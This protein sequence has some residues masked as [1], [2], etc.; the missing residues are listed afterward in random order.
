M[1]PPHERNKPFNNRTK[2]TACTTIFFFFL[3]LVFWLQWFLANK[4][5]ITP[6]A[7][8][9][10]SISFIPDSSHPQQKPQGLRTFKPLSWVC[11]RTVLKSCWYEMFVR[12]IT[13]EYAC[14]TLPPP[15]HPQPSMHTVTE[16]HTKSKPHNGFTCMSRY[17]T[18]KKKPKQNRISLT[19]R[20]CNHL[21]QH[22]TWK[23]HI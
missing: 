7:A 15:T 2:N 19:S 16:P 10:C 8:A 18:G 9:Y 3:M 17:L 6:C 5:P 1:T 20:S 12:S 14:V 21:L 11:S 23:V 22:G 13:P 4:C